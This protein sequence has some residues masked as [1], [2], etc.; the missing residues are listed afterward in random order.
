MDGVHDM[1]GMHG[2]GPFNLSRDKP[3]SKTD[4][5]ARM[6]AMDLSF[7]QP[8]GFNV[9]RMRHAMECMPSEAY[10]TSEY[11]DRWYWRGCWYS[12]QRRLGQHR[13]VDKRCGN[14]LAKRH[15]RSAAT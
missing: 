9:D 12:G 14:Q 5:R 15:R 4:W 13:R 1:G 2:F 11:F 6:F 10:L 7:T 3:L 8:S